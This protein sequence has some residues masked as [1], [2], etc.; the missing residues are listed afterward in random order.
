[1]RSGKK[2]FGEVAFEK[3]YLTSDRLY[4]ALA[5]QARD[6]ARNM[7]YRFLGQVLLDLGYLTERQVLDV[8][9]ELHSTE[10]VKEGVV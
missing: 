2:L 8:L 7:P 6:E 10:T 3:G 4:E 5:I 9:N 1:M